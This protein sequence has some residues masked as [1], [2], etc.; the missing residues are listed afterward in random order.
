MFRPYLS[1]KKML[2][3]QTF[4]AAQSAGATKFIFCSSMSAFGK[5]SVDEVNPDTPVC[6]PDDYGRAII[7]KFC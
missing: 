5:I 2:I 1:L 7:E 4:E 6:E 3:W